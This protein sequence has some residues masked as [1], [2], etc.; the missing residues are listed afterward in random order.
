MIRHNYRW[1]F[2]RFKQGYAAH[3]CYVELTDGIPT[4]ATPVHDMSRYRS[5]V[6]E[7]HQKDFIKIEQNGDMRILKNNQKRCAMCRVCG[8]FMYQLESTKGDTHTGCATMIT[9][10]SG[11]AKQ[12][13]KPFKQG[14][15]HV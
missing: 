7:A 1:V 9:V 8:G 13:D 6:F 4:Y 14:A 5:A 3:L 2:S 11:N 15:V 12:G 10:R